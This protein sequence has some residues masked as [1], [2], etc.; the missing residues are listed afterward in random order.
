M[1]FNT[2]DSTLLHKLLYVAVGGEAAQYKP[3]NEHPQLQYEAVVRG[4]SGRYQCASGLTTLVG[5]L[6]LFDCSGARLA[7]FAQKLVQETSG[8]SR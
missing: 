4:V 8:Y 1:L 7:T 3:S 6:Q 2:A 5:V